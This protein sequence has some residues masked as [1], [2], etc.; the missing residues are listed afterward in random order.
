MDRI[1]IINYLIGKNN[2][3][4]YLEIGVRNPD[5]CFNKI[6]C[7][8]KH[9]VDPGYEGDFKFDFKMTS[10]E[11]FNQN[12]NKYDLIFIDGSH[13]DH[14]VEKDIYNSLMSLNDNGFIVLHDCYPP[15]IYH[16][17]EDY[18]DNSTPAG[19]HWN[20]TVW[21]A[22]VKVRSELKDIFSC[23]VD[24][25]WGVGII[26]KTKTPNPITNENV[27]FSYREFEKNVKYYLNLISP[28]EFEN[29]FYASNKL[30]LTWL[31]KFDDHSSM[32]ILSQ[33]I[34][35]NL[36]N[37]DVTCKSIIGKT[38]TKNEFVLNC[39]QKE[40]DNEL[41]IMFSYPDMIGEL[42]NFKTK[43]IYTGVDTTGGIPN[44]TQNCNKA[45]FL[46]TPSLISK[47]RMIDLGV[48]KP[49]FV[50]PHGIEKN[51]FP[52][53]Q[54]KKSNKF[55]F[56]Y[57]GEC[58]D[59][60]GTFHLVD[61]FIN[62]FGD[63]ENVELILRSNDA[64]LFYGGEELKRIIEP[65]KNIVWDHTNTT[66]DELCKLYEDCHA[67]VYP[68]RADTF[69]MT[70]LEAMSSGLPIISTMEPGVVELIDKRY[71]VIHTTLVKVEGHPWMLGDWGEPNQNGLRSSMLWMYEN[72]DY[73]NW[74]ELEKHSKYVNEELN[75]EK[76][77][78]KFQTEILPKLKKEVKILTLLTSYERPNHIPNVIESFKQI[79]EDGIN[80]HIYIVENSESNKKSEI[81]DIINSKIDENFTLYISEFNM[82][83]R[84][85]LLQ[86]LDMVNIDDYGFIQFSDQ[87]NIFIEPLSTYCDILHQNQDIGFVTG[88]M[89]KEHNELGWRQTRFG[90]LCEK[91]S[92]RAG[93]MFM[94]VSDLKKLFPLH[95][96]AHYGQPYNSSW[97]AGLDW[98]LSYWNPNSIGKNSNHNFVLCVPGGVLH[99]GY[100]S[101]IYD[102][103]VE[104]NE[105][106]LEELLSMR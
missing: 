36:K 52:F 37:V 77:T 47:Q 4:S 26:T 7:D 42:D 19:G 46:L 9:G 45:D 69:G 82:G 31:A 18:G 57:I 68:S 97:N 20:G 61:A 58:S 17:R 62:L 25:D 98:E 95:L 51:K 93:H 103:P 106:R 59:R 41:G 23:V 12:E 6:I 24:C 101:T 40:S 85:A 28:N 33:R 10:D 55:K 87:D 1:Q 73:L 2:F 5:H 60:K 104:E 84:G 35:E 34:V 13:I 15:T 80:N 64:M 29:I 39:L 96:D 67:Y 86:V 54:R 105:Y 22:F 56:L 90:N 83:Q 14:Q 50:F 27:Y 44:F 71:D 79:R 43:V 92:L 70:L 30:Q 11:F 16:Q 32:G 63:N 8:L 3:K 76:L 88:Y 91:R 75:W 49:I 99:V 48:K 74:H 21:K 94:R 65:Y 89:S 81:I 100:D 72:Y 102:W 78:Q 53:K 66:H 38:E